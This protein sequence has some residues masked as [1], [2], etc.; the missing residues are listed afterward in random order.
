LVLPILKISYILSSVQ[1]LK[2]NR[3]ESYRERRE[4]RFTKDLIAELEKFVEV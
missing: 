1:E 4:K 2:R 3:K